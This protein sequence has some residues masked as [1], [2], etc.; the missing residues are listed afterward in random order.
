MVQKLSTA[1]WTF[2]QQ[3]DYYLQ[4]MRHTNWVRAHHRMVG[5]VGEPATWIV[6]NYCLRTRITFRKDG[7]VLLATAYRR[8]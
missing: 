6:E 8:K 3:L 5:K 2:Q 1:D 7:R 4:A